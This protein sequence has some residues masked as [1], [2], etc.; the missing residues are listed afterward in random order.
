[1]FKEIERNEDKDVN[2]LF[3]SMMK[4]YPFSKS[5]QQVFHKQFLK[6]ETEELLKHLSEI[7][8]Q[9]ELRLKF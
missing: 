2:F 6:I 5:I 3:Q 8:K 4:K 7:K 9:N 1:M